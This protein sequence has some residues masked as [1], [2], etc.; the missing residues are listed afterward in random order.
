MT[1]SRAEGGPTPHPMSRRRRQITRVPENPTMTP[2]APILAPAASSLTSRHDGGSDSTTQVAY[3]NV[4]C[5]GG[6]NHPSVV[7]G[8]LYDLGLAAQVV[9]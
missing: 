4:H 8:K 3:R 6:G 5:T 9:E 2:G 7:A 1:A